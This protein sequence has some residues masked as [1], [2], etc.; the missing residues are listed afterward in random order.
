MVSV[1]H[2]EIACRSVGTKRTVQ[3][4]FRLSFVKTPGPRL[5]HDLRR[6]LHDPPTSLTPT[7]AV[8]RCLHQRVALS[9]L[10]IRGSVVTAAGLVFAFTMAS[11]I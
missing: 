7:D 1:G 8:Q 6:S 2:C 11:F 5:L 4:I 10:V 9:W 3:G